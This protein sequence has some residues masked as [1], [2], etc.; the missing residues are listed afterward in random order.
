MH[1]IVYNPIIINTQNNKKEK[2]LHTHT[3]MYVCVCTE[4][5]SSHETKQ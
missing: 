4:P 2:Q 5:S 1:A 3:Y